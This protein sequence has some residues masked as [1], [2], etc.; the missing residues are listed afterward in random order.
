MT[1]LQEHL[2]LLRQL[3]RGPVKLPPHEAAAG[4]ELVKAGLACV[5][6]RHHHEITPA[7]RRFIAA[8]RSRVAKRR[9]GEATMRVRAIGEGRPGF[10]PEDGRNQS[11]PLVAT[12]SR[13]CVKRY[14]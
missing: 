2:T 10:E 4:G 11:T 9:D 8:S 13:Q 7:G 3:A 1:K 6:S 5:I 12:L 14:V